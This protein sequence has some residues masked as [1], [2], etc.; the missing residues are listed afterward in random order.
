MKPLISSHLVLVLLSLLVGC[1]SYYSRWQL[2]KVDQAVE[3]GDLKRAIEIFENLQRLNLNMEDKLE[4]ARR[5]SRMAHRDARQY[6]AAIR[7]YRVLVLHSPDAAERIAAQ[8]M[9]ANINFENLA[10]Y[11]QAIVEYSKLLSLKP[12]T[13]AAFRYRLNLAKSYFNLNQFQQA[14]MEVDVL[15]KETTSS[16]QRFDLLVFKGNLLLTTKRLEEA[17]E[18][19]EGMIKEFPERSTKENVRLSLALSYEELSQF[20]KAIEILSKMRDHYPHPEFIDLKIARLKGR[21][22]NLP[23]ARG[24]R[25]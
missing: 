13:D 18:L 7:F 24:L 4:V 17:I 6:P 8:E 10:D 22:E 25:K 5:G 12:D 19:F 23:G 20:Q 9:I 16:Q 1:T 11:E 2:R 15:L 21:L 14:T 3:K